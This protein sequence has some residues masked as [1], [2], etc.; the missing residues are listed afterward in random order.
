V[1]DGGRHIPEQLV[2]RG[3]VVQR[4]HHT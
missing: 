4:Q 1:L 3:G 2:E